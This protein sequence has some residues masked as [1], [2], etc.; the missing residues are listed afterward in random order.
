[1]IIGCKVNSL[2]E[3]G[4][5]WHCLRLS[6]CSHQYFAGLFVCLTYWAKLYSLKWSNGF[7]NETILEEEENK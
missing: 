7:D 6:L 4:N 1:M 5:S 3:S 2:A